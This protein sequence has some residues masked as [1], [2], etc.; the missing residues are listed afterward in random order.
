[1]RRRLWVTVVEILDDT[2]DSGRSRR[3]TRAHQTLLAEG[4]DV[5][6]RA[7]DVPEV[8]MN[9]TTTPLRSD[10]GSHDA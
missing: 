6:F 5:Q 10:K 1:M 4:V 3:K 2:T 9:M 7:L 8:R